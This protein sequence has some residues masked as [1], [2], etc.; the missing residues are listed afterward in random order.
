[1]PWTI[2]RRGFWRLSPLFF[3][4]TPAI[5]NGSGAIL[6][7]FSPWLRELAVSHQP[8]VLE[9]TLKPQLF[10]SNA[11]VWPIVYFIEGNYF[12]TFFLFSCRK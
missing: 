9:S 1:M 10:S 6:S 7:A 2:E 4:V 3:P 8:T 12:G 5:K 11:S